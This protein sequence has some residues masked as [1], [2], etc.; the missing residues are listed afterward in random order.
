[1][2]TVIE[3][4]ERALRR[5]RAA[6]LKRAGISEDELRRQAETYQLTAEQMDPGRRQQY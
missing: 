4:S 3:K 6:L 5:E 1:M 2:S